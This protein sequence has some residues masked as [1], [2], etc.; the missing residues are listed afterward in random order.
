MK[1][2]GI[3]DVFRYGGRRIC[4]KMYWEKRVS[5]MKSEAFSHIPGQ[6]EISNQLVRI[7]YKK[8]HPVFRM[9]L[10]SLIYKEKKREKKS[11][12]LPV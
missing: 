5:C 7:F 8:V 12:Y 9:F 6:N 4:P 1:I 10:S 2:S 11:K 3:L